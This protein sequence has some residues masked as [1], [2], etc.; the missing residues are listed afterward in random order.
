MRIFTTELRKLFSNK[1]F[2]LIISAVFIMNGYLMFRTANSAEAT[3]A[4]YRTI[5]AELEGLSDE[6]KLAF[7]DERIKHS[8]SGLYNYNW[9][10]FYELANECYDVVNYKTYLENIDAQAESMSSISIFSDPDTFN[11]RSIVKTPPAYENVQDVVPVIDVSQGIVLATDNSF[12]DILIGF[13]ALFSVLSIMLSDRES[14][15]SRFLFSLK[16]GRGSLLLSKCRVLASVLFASVSLIYI[17]N[18]LISGYIYGLG[19]LSRPVQSVRGFIGCNLNIS[20][21][22]Y[23]I[24]YIIFKFAAMLVIGLILTCIAVNT[25][26][27]FSFFGVSAAVMI[28]EAVAY[29]EIQPLSI[30]SIFR[31]INIISFTKVNEIFSSYK[32]INFREYP[33]PLIES[34]ALAILIIAVLALGLSAFL[35]AK[36]RNLEFRKISLKIK[37]GAEQKIHSQLYYELYSVCSTT[38]KARRSFALECFFSC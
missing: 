32:N 25:K 23:L 18:L 9:K 22:E 34:A 30:Y 13:I 1:I 6:E 15:M 35:Y 36:R 38:E 5:Y 12:T 27:F 4:E 10:L 29:S 19:D 26:N 21:L 7:F 3:P 24:L 11:Y 31:Y 37:S 14:G 28:A 33:I 8:A 2:F 20:V 17:E 16:R